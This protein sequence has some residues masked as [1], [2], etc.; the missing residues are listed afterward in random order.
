[1]FKE[2]IPF[3]QEINVTNVYQ[4]ISAGFKPKASQ[5]YLKRQTQ[6]CEW[7]LRRLSTGFVSDSNFL[8][9]VTIFASVF[10]PKS[11]KLFFR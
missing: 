9:R 6:Q 1:M 3:L 7:A 5:Y 2:S 8:K 4:V 11:G 10:L